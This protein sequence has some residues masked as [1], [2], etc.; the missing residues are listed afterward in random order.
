M[1][2]FNMISGQSN[3]Y[4]TPLVSWTTGLDRRARKCRPLLGALSVAVAVLTLGGEAQAAP[5]SRAFGKNSSLQTGFAREKITPPLGT[6][7]MGFASRDYKQGCR[8]IHDDLYIRALFL[9][10]G[11]ERLLIL[12]YDLCFLGREEADRF[13]GALGREFDLSPRQILL[14]SSHNHAGAMV[15][16]WYWAGVFPP[17]RSYLNRLTQVTLTAAR[18]AHDNARE[19]K[20]S[21]RV[22]KTTLPMSRRKP[23]GKGDTAFAPNPDGQIYDRLPILM[24][25]DK[26]DKPI[27]LMFSVSAHPS[28]VM[29][30]DISADYPG[31]ACQLLDEHLSSTAAMFVQGCGGDANTRIMGESSD[32]W[33]R[34]SWDEVEK[35]GR[36]MA[37]EVIR[38]LDMGL[39]PI[40]PSL[41]S[42]IT[43]MRLPLKKLPPRSEFE[44]IVNQTKPEVRESNMRCQ[45][46]TRQLEKLDRGEH[47]PTNVGI[48][49]QVVHV[50]DGV[51]L[52]GMEGEPVA[53]WGY[54][55]E[56]F[57]GAGVTF[58]LGY[59]NGQGLYLP[60]SNML[61]EGGYEVVSY[62]EYGLAAPLAPGLDEVA[63][64]NLRCLA[65]RVGGLR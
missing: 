20:M 8:A 3:A 64:E 52:V 45:W 17:D 59:C 62:W 57:C 26:A 25:K 38:T 27:C 56:D 15:G 24:L 31:A 33:R 37:D 6:R 55:I 65:G 22:G 11:D 53:G 2:G 29:G 44:A 49:V 43:E 28:M 5:A 30:W 32:K 46:A 58:P 61:P 13:K 9:K 23:D 36:Q 50:G 35:A 10:Q 16:T 19:A 34:A 12:A 51:N 1:F 48:T 21:A 18:R 41:R 39:K 42:A 40:K 47:L 7:M 54:L 60:V 14:N 63:L 4:A